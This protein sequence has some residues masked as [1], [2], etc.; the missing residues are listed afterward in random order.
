MLELVN[1]SKTFTGAHRV[2]AVRDVSLKVEAGGIYGIIGASGA[3]KSTLVRCMNLLERPDSGRVLLNG[4]DLMTLKPDQLRA[5]RRAI[6]MIFQHF[7]LMS[8][9]TALHNVM[10]PLRDAHIS[11]AEAMNKALAMLQLVGLEDKVDA[12]PSQLSGGQKQRVAIA[13]ALSYDPA[14]LLCDEAT[15]ALDPQTTLSILELL[16][17]L[18]EQL[19][20]TIVIITHEMSVIK[21]ICHRVAV[22]EDGRIAEEGDVYTIFS[23]PHKAVTQRFIQTT[24]SLSKIEKLL[25][26]N[27]EVVRLLPGD[28]LLK[29]R[30]GRESAGHALISDVSRRFGVDM[31]IIFGDIEI[32][33]D[34]PLGGLIVV[35]QGGENTVQQ[36]VEYLREHGVG[37]EVLKH[38]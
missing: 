27:N 23:N 31:N 20:L 7:A 28:A 36:S 35:A 1:I 24:S 38:A 16:R 21:E 9:R 30:F 13:R 19:G 5:Q 29:L 25:A 3:G 6:G 18:N 37:V 15:S 33:R 10:L 17:Q 34:A 14:L 4:Q 11:R 8:S 2:E 22:M 12:Y 32:L 26:S